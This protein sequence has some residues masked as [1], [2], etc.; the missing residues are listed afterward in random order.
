MKKRLK[1]NQNNSIALDIYF[2]IV[3]KNKKERN[4][5]SYKE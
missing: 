4:V 3:G 1:I 2:I 5:D